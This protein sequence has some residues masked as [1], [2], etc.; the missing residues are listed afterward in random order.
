MNTKLK[1]QNRI[2]MMSIT[3]HSQKQNGPRYEFDSS[4]LFLFL[5]EEDAIKSS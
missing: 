5:S 4:I 3:L 2:M 1:T